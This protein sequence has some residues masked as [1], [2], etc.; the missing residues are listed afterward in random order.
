MEVPPLNGIL[1]VYR[2]K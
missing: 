2:F 1:L